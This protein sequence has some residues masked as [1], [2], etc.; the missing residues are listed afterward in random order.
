VLIFLL[1]FLTSIR[2]VLSHAR[3]ILEDASVHHTA[4][5]V[6]IPMNRFFVFSLLASTAAWILIRT[7]NS[8]DR[9]IPVT[10]AAAKLQQAW[11]DHHTTA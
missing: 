8:R 7:S 10:E 5:E 11:A 2:D 9:A 4:H 3:V 1:L 6:I